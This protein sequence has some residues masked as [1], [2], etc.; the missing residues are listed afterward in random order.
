MIR[1]SA[2]FLIGLLI[3]VSSFTVLAEEAPV[4]LCTGGQ[5]G[6][7]FSAGRDIAAHANPR[8]L[9]VTVT[10]TSG[11]MET[12]NLLMTSF[13]Y[14]RIPAFLISSESPSLRMKSE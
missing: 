14:G 5:E 12:L 9:K 4:T 1:L 7:Y 6:N 3:A 13:L 11:S 8:Y 2:T 10:E